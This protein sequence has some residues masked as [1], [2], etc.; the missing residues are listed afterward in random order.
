VFEGEGKDSWRHRQAG[1]A[2]VSLVSAKEIVSYRSV[3]GVPGI[4]AI[5]NDFQDVDLVLVEGFNAEPGARIE[6]RRA[7]GAGIE[8]EEKN[9]AP[10]A[11]VETEKSNGHPSYKPNDIIPLADLIVREVLA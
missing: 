7:N 6:V 9:G 2:A 1:A 4:E 8:R 3:D 11:V 10:L 5:R